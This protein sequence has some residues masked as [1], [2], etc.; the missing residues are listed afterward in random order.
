M[1]RG[2]TATCQPQRFETRP[3]SVRKA[4]SSY[5]DFIPIQSIEPKEIVR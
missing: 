2:A 4:L 1:L 5:G 3:K